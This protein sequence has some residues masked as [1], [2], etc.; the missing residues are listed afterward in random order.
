MQHA[1]R[2]AHASAAISVTRFGAQTS[3]PARQE[4]DSFLAQQ[5]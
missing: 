4:V 2:F 5:A 3:I 1:I